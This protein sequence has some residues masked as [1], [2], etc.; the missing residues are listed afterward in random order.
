MDSRDR[1]F[2]RRA[3]QT[4]HNYRETESNYRETEL[5][6]RKKIKQLSRKQR[7]IESKLQDQEKY[8]QAKHYLPLLR[9]MI[10]CQTESLTIEIRIDQLQIRIDQLQKRIQ[11][12]EEKWNRLR[13]EQFRQQAIRDLC[14][15]A[16]KLSGHNG[17]NFFTQAG[18][19]NDKEKGIKL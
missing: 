15:D 7:A 4:A 14:S 13:K 3:E 17:A 5:K 18:L 2:L 6:L 8:K 19:T 12:H 10:A 1:K 16:S 9:A 11:A